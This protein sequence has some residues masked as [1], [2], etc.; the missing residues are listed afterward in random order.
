MK[1]VKIKTNGYAAQ[2][3][4][5]RL[6][7]AFG[8]IRTVVNKVRPHKVQD[9]R[10]SRGK[11]RPSMKEALPALGE[12]IYVARV[13]K[14][15]TQQELADAIGRELGGSVRQSYIC[16]VERSASG[17]SVDRLATICDILEL[18][19]QDLFEL[20]WRLIKDKGVD[21]AELLSKTAAKLAKAL[22]RKT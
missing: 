21:D 8:Q 3:G 1:G 9:G 11:K 20:A 14:G 17:I 12:A 4:R 15:F 22:R 7:D 19:L 2:G 18:N 5:N 10:R 13:L 6:A 16:G